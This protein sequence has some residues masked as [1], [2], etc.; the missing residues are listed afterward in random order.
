VSRIS[1]RSIIKFVEGNWKLPSIS[2]SFDAIAGSL[3]NM[4]AFNRHSQNRK[5]FL[6]PITGQ[7]F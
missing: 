2:G 3:N 5:L 1:R 7:P 4:F 6:D